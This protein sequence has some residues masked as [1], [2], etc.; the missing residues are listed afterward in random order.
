MS[1]TE[2]GTSRSEVSEIFSAGYDAIA[3][4]EPPSIDLVSKTF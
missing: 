2:A 1:Q 4:D 3:Q